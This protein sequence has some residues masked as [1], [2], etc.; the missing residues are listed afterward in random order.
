VP[1]AKQAVQILEELFLH[2]GHTGLVFPAEGQKGRCMSDNT[3]N[4]A[5]RA[6]GYTKEMATAHGFRATARTLIV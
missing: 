1:L 3:L 5:F 6:M 2:T 4:A